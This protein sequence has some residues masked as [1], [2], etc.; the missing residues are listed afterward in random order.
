MKKKKKKKIIQVN[1]IC[2]QNRIFICQ[3][4]IISSM[5][6]RLRIS[7]SWIFICII[8]HTRYFLRKSS[9]I[10]YYICFHT[11]NWFISTSLPREAERADRNLIE[12]WISNF[13][14]MIN[15]WNEFMHVLIYSHFTVSFFL[16]LSFTFL[17]KQNLLSNIV[18]WDLI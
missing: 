14:G 17:L 13:N 11:K 16:Y 9:W 4:A 8:L 15:G 5:S 18:M 1:N 12:L 6:L 10:M 7:M 3:C 2:R